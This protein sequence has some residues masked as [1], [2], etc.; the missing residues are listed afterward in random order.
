MYYFPA[1]TYLVAQ[2]DIKAPRDMGDHILRIL[3]EFFQRYGYWTI[4]GGLLLENAGVP[5]PGETILLFASFLASSKHTLHLPWIILI[6]VAAAVTGDNIG[7]SI[8]RF[9]GRPLLERYKR[10]FRLR[11][12]TIS[13]GENLI[14]EHGAATVFSARFIAGLRVVAG[15]MAGILHMHW[16]RFLVFNFLGALAWVT[17]IASIGYFFGDRLAWVIH[18]MGRVNLAILIT[19]TALAAIWLH[20]R[21]RTQKHDTTSPSRAAQEITGNETGSVSGASIKQKLIFLTCG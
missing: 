5:V 20:R 10:V 9:G 16:T 17:T 1:E 15:P 2:I 8:G 6:A 12:D 11:G 21:R 4:F 18:V 13:K 19:V 3:A 7:Y 14:S